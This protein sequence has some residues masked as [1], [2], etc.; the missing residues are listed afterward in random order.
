MDFKILKK[1]RYLLFF[2]NI[3]FALT[4]ILA[5]E[6][7]IINSEALI[8]DKI[9]NKATFN[10]DVVV[11]FQD[12]KLCSSRL[13]IHYNDEKKGIKKITMPEKIR[14][15]RNKTNEVIIADKGEFDNIKKEL[16]LEGNIRI[17]K[18]DTI[19]FTD[20]LIY[21]AKLTNIKFK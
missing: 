4:T 10:D 8:I 16:I 15:M 5:D 2:T 17:Q 19:I 7:L 18:D 6:E 20:K 3:L 9:N 12:F 13:I 14:L 11:I 21:L 1:I